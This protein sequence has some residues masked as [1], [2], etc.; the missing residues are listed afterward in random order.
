MEEE[1]E[2]CGAVVKVV[3]EG[4]APS[5]NLSAWIN[6]G[7]GVVLCADCWKRLKDGERVHEI[8]MKVTTH[9]AD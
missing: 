9:D 5:P 6:K 1:C 8:E 4:C 3:V 2:I 7:E